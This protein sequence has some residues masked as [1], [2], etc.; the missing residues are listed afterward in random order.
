MIYNDMFI[1]KTY[2][3][4]YF[5]PTVHFSVN[6]QYQKYI[7]K[8]FNKDIRLITYVPNIKNRLNNFSAKKVK[9]L[10]GKFKVIKNNNFKIYGF[11]TF[12]DFLSI[13]SEVKVLIDNICEDFTE[14]KS[15][16]ICFYIHKTLLF[17]EDLVEISPVFYIFCSKLIQIC[18]TL[19]E[20]YKFRRDNSYNRMF[21]DFFENL[22]QDISTYIEKSIDI[23]DS[24]FIFYT[25]KI[26]QLEIPK[27][28]VLLSMK[29]KKENYEEYTGKFYAGINTQN[30]IYHISSIK[31]FVNVHL[32]HYISQNIPLRKCKNC[33]CYFIASNRKAMYCEQISPQNP[34]KSCKTLRTKLN[35]KQTEQKQEIE[36]LYDVFS[37]MCSNRRKKDEEK[38][39]NIWSNFKKEY[40]EK[41]NATYGPNYKRSTMIEW[42]NQVIKTPELLYNSNFNFEFNYATND[43]IQKIFDEWNN[44]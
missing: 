27:N 39:S 15:K 16:N 21:S 38:Y 30:H 10:K 9:K 11:Y 28:T 29:S 1:E 43:D 6:R 24:T 40:K 44:M 5:L 3:S 18:N 19:H 17:C 7:I 34:K 33:N 23:I 14:Q 35:K 25:P 8:T 2:D 12:L 42:L 22:Y 13:Y 37:A 41:Y 20:K 26:Y 4:L 36:R 31:D 32:Y